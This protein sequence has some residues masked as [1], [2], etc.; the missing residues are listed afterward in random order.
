MGW[1]PIWTVALGERRAHLNGG[2]G[3]KAT[4][5]QIRARTHTSIASCSRPSGFRIQVI[6]LEFF[7][8]FLP[9]GCG[10]RGS[11][12]G[13]RASVLDCRVSILDFRAS[14]LDCRASVLGLRMHRLAISFR[15]SCLDLGVRAQ[16][17]EGRTQGRP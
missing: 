13:F 14:V 16:G 8:I 9:P 12:F 7:V 17:L 6:L 15:A 11:V 1:A 10:F 5:S 4:L 2:F 3:G